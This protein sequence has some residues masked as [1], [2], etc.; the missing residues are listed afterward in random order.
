[1]AW[2]A[3]HNPSI[4]I[5]VF[6]MSEPSWIGDDGLTNHCEACECKH[7]GECDGY[8]PNEPDRVEDVF[9]D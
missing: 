6:E 3:I 1:M 2:Y 4:D 8:N 9:G 5:G 7:S